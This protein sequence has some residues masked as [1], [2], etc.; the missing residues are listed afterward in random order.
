M[1]FVRGTQRTL[2]REQGENVNNAKGEIDQTCVMTRGRAWLAGVVLVGLVAGCAAREGPAPTVRTTSS[3]AT[4]PPVPRPLNLAAH[5]EDPCL[6]AF[7]DLGAAGFGGEY[8]EIVTTDKCFYEAAEGGGGGLALSLFVDS[9]PLAAAYKRDADHY[10]LFEPRDLVGYPAVVEA[11][12]IVGGTCAVVVGTAD[13]QGLIL[14]KYP[15][16]GADPG[17]LTA[18]C[19]KVR[20]LA[21]LALRRLG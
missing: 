7:S 8:R 4:V 1:P 13:D 10:E 20:A 12:K 5:R 17:G 6:V 14:L 9:S 18:V 16:K 2:R 15:D 11:E 19:D 3:S 21:E